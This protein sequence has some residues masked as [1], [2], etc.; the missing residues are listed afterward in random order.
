MWD[1]IGAK[2]K[3]FA[4]VIAWVGIISSI[5]GGIVL[6]VQ[7]ININHNRWIS[8]GGGLLIFGGFGI[9]IGGSIL[10][11]VSSFFMYGFGELIE[12]SEE[13][14]NNNLKNE[15]TSISN[16]FI[17][18]NKTCPF[19]AEE[20]KF[21][22]KF[23]PHCGQNVNEYELKQKS[24]EEENKNKK[25]QEMKENFKN[26]NDVF[27]NEEIMKK[28]NEIR[29]I[30]GKGLYISYLKNKAKEFGLGDIEINENDIE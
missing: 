13:I 21:E 11:W 7:G 23:C 4:K 20:I 9:I 10:S 27:N 2:I 1:E 26:M 5:I 22:A 6:I 15:R 14:K 16:N 8:S 18:K 29:R 3:I 12:N 30:Y 19:C 28:A 25:E 24:I 17:N